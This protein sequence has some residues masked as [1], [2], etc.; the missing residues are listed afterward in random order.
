VSGAVSTPSQKILR[1]KFVVTATGANQAVLRPMEDP[2]LGRVIVEY[3]RGSLPNNGQVIDADSAPLE[4]VQISQ[5]PD[6]TK[7][8]RV[9]ES[10]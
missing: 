8:V 6:G 5:S 7:T 4:I 3:Q 9:R 10:R 1:G 2:K